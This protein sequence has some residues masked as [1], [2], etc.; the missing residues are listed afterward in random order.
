MSQQ[1]TVSISHI[2]ICTSNLDRS[3]QFYTEALGFALDRSIDDIGQPYDKLME[4]PG[5]QCR[6]QYLKCGAV[7]IELIGY[8]GSKVTGSTERRSMNQLGF[9]HMTLLVD[10]INAVVDRVVKYGGHVHPETKID[11]PYGPMVFCTDPDG[12]RIEIIQFTS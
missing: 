9:T 5:V 12:V 1:P 2:G 11:S 10:D 4:L 7:T 3:I 6:V 8:P